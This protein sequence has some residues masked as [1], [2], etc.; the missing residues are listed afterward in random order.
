MIWLRIYLLVGLIAH[1]ALWEALK[2]RS[3]DCAAKRERQPLNLRLV[4]VIKIAILL[5][6]VA[7]TMAPDIL[8]I[9]SS[10]FWLRVTGVLIYTAGLIIAMLGRVQLGENWSDIETAQVLPDQAVVSRGLYRYIRHPIYV[11]DL[12][13]L[14][15][16]ELSLNSWL[17]LA[18]GVLAPVVLWKAVREER[19]LIK[20]LPGYDAYCARTKRFIPFVV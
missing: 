18:V 2:Q 9:S 8:P 19:M 14:T 1:K 16:L 12:L 13:L 7:Q 4:K 10:P 11:G 20:S 15:G 17:A 5:S 3:P 6:V